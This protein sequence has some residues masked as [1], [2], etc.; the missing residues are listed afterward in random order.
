MRVL[1]HVKST[2]VQ[3]LLYQFTTNKPVFD[4]LTKLLYSLRSYAFVFDYAQNMEL[5]IFN[6]KHPSC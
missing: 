6:V 4:K 3:R 5:L 1:V 2:R